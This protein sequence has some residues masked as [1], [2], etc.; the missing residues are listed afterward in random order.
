MP[1]RVPELFGKMSVKPDQVALT[2]LFN[3][4]AKLTD[5]NS[6]KAGRDVLKRIPSSFL[7]D[8]YLVNSAFNMLMKFGDVAEAERLFER[9]ER[10]S[11]V[12]YGA[13]MKGNSHDV[14]SF[15]GVE[16]TVSFRI[17]HQ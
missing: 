10:K 15:E 14:H 13:L 2:L 9:L 11:V 8:D 1:E 12:S 17:R 5:A 7:A 3:A 6:I 4:F 16:L